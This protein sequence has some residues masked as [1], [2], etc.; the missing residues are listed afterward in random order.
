MSTNEHGVDHD[1]PYRDCRRLGLRCVDCL[2]HRL[3]C[4]LCI[5]AR[6]E[7]TSAG[8]GDADA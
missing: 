5:A 3:W 6:T 4:D 2:P 7:G 1:T 8:T